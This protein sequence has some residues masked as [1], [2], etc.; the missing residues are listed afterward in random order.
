M[1]SLC[2]FAANRLLDTLTPFSR[3]TISHFRISSFQNSIEST[4]FILFLFQCFNFLNHHLY[5]ISK[6]FWLSKYQVMS[7]PRLTNSI[8]V[9]YPYNFFFLFFYNQIHTQLPILEIP[10]FCGVLSKARI[11]QHRNQPFLI[12]PTIVI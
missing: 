1:K 4:T 7:F 6:F 3:Q 11:F 2:R 10:V 5:L 9:L 8:I 12:E